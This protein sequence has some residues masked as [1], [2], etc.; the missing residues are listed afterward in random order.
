MSQALNKV[1]DMIQSNQTKISELDAGVS[2]LS[3]ALPMTW[4]NALQN[5]ENQLPPNV[6]TQLSGQIDAVSA[7]M[8]AL[9]TNASELNKFV[10]R[11]CA[12]R[13][14]GSRNLTKTDAYD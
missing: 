11:L 2:T 3:I 14:R 10:D 6:R 13:K 9:L 12:I 7:Q 4:Q 5:F 8:E 1:T